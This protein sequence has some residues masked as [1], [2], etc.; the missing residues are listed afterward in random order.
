[1][2]LYKDL[3]SCSGQHRC[4]WLPLLCLLF[5]P[6]ASATAIPRLHFAGRFLADVPTLNNEL[7]NFNIDNFVFHKDPGF[8]KMGSGDFRLVNCSVTQ[9]CLTDGSC[10]DD[11]PIVGQ[12]IIRRASRRHSDEIRKH[13]V[14]L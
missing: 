4:P 14:D 6:T 12:P 8:N 7:D 10:V 1:M 5:C 9:V 2:Y 3:R 13:V 11:D